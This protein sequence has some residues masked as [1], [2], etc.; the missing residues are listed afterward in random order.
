MG[1]YAQARPFYE[2]AVEEKRQGDADGRVD[3]ES[4]GS[5]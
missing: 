5:C 3:H 1:E 2:E 4:L